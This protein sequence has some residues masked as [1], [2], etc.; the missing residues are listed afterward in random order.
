L[1]SD[2]DKKPFI[3]EAERLR[4]IHKREHPDY[5]YQPRRRKQNKGPGEQMLQLPHGQNVTFSRSLKQEDSPCSPRSHSSTSPSTCSSQPHSPAVQSQTLRSCLDQSHNLDFNRLSEMDNT[6]IAEDCLD[7]SDLDQYFPSETSQSY[8]NNYPQNYIKH[9]TEEET[10]NNYKN[11][12]LCTESVPHSQPVETYDE[13]IPPSIGRYHE[14]QPSSVVKAE[15][16]VSPNASVMY[17]YQSGMPIGSTST[18]YTNSSHQY[19]PSYQYLPQRTVF[20]NTTLTSYNTDS[21]SEPW[22]H[23][24]L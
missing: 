1:L 12:R 17:S 9:S 19:L 13:T 14:L 7:S 3:E 16:F 10:N 11:K 5:K 2:V 4:V 23:Y 15:R 8:Q 6:Y 22:G 18:Y 20:G 24:T 21:N